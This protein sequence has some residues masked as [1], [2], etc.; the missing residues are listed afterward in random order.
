MKRE[1]ARSGA[2]SKAGG[3]RVDRVALLEK[4]AELGSITA[5]AKAMAAATRA[6]CSVVADTL[7][8]PMPDCAS[9]GSLRTKKSTGGNV[10]VGDLLNF[11]QVGGGSGGGGSG[12][13]SGGS[14]SDDQYMPEGWTPNH[15]NDWERGYTYDETAGRWRKPG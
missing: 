15:R 14:S 7:P 3:R 5:A 12:G 8:C 9:C 10:D 6:I 13:G 2:P 11:G 4:V 1:D